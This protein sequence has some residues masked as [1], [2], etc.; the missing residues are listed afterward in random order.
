M[1]FREEHLERA[2]RLILWGCRGHLHYDEIAGIAGEALNGSEQ[3][4]RNF[5]SE[6]INKEMKRAG[7]AAEKKLRQARER[8]RET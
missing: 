6:R 2:L 3:L 5:E 4:I 7:A 1:T 8:E